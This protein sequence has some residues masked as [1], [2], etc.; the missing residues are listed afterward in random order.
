M[1]SFVV[2]VASAPAGASFTA[3][4]LT[5]MVFGAGSKAGPPVSRTL[6]VKLA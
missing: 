3:V 5:V 6:K 2:T 4:T 1:S